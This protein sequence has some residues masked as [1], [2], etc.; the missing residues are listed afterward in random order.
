MLFP[1]VGVHI[2]C[3]H[4]MQR[5]VEY[6]TNVMRPTP[7]NDIFGTED[8]G[9]RIPA[10]L[11]EMYEVYQSRIYWK[12]GVGDYYRAGR[13]LWKVE[14]PH[15]YYYNNNFHGDT[16]IKLYSNLEW[17]W[18]SPYAVVSLFSFPLS[19]VLHKCVLLEVG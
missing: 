6:R 14:E 16:H 9:T 12:N 18:R 3:F 5:L 13:P 17:P 7:N 1:W 11:G 15:R 19:F 2:K 8:K 10:S 4:L